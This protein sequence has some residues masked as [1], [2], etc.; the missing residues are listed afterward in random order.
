MVGVTAYLMLQYRV[1]LFAVNK[2]DTVDTWRNCFQYPA[3]S[4]VAAWHEEAKIHLTAWVLS[5]D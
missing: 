3:A 4:A 5:A 2:S 1:C